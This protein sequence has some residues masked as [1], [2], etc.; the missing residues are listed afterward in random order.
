[1]HASINLRTFVFVFVF[2]NVNL[3]FSIEAPDSNG[4]VKNT[5]ELPSFDKFFHGMYDYLEKMYGQLITKITLMAPLLIKVEEI[6]VA[7]RTQ[8][9]PRLGSY[10][11]HWEKKL[12]EAI[13]N[14]M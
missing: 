12:F 5:T 10:Y 2:V 8:R 4:G 1:M 14:A 6:L 11:H 3:L 7:T 9:A 13:G